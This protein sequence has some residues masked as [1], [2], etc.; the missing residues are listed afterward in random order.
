VYPANG[1]WS[2]VS[3]CRLR[4]VYGRRSRHDRQQPVGAVHRPLGGD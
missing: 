4:D 1:L 2:D 3:I